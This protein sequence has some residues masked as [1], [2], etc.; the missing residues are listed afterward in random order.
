MPDIARRRLLAGTL[1]A[2]AAPAFVRDARAEDK[3]ALHAQAKL[4][5]T[6]MTTLFKIVSVRDEIV[7]GLTDAE[8]DA[9]GG[10][11]A[12]AVARALKTRGEI[13]AWQYAVRK[14]ATGELE[15]APRQKIGLLAHDSLRV[16]PY[17]TPLA[18]RAHD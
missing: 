16:E 8:L 11:D 10:R 13:T 7:I 14:S 5:E 1:L 3:S 6:T 17:P 18:V 9:L 2:A 15:Q 4:S 12:G